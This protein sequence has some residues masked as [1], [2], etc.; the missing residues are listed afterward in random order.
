MKIC[1][2]IISYLPDDKTNRDIRLSRLNSLIN[3]CNFLFDI[4]IMIIAQNWD[5]IK[6]NGEFKRKSNL[7]VYR[8]ENK[9]GITGARRELRK[10]FLESDFDYLVMLD[11]DANLVGLK[12]DADLYLNTIRSNPG[13][14]G[15][16]K[17]FLLK[18]FAISKDVYKLVDF[19]E[20]EAENGDF[21]EDMWLIMYLDKMHSNKKFLF[22]RTSLN[23]KSDSSKD[24][25]STWYH[26]QFNKH[27]IGDNTR[28]MIKDLK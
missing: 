11:D 16:Y 27:N 18:L 3:K 9:L 25:Y 14:W 24:P 21:F 17:T 5:N 22:K 19:P 20:G 6:L 8:Y 10:K 1:I 26:N 13:K 12:E 7:I 4:P 23:D 15:A 28:A 2:G